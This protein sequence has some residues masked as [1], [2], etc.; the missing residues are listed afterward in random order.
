VLTLGGVVYKKLYR[1]VQERA[2]VDQ[3]P[4][5]RTADGMTAGH[6]GVAFYH[7]AIAEDKG[8]PGQTVKEFRIGLHLALFAD[9]Q[10]RHLNHGIVNA[11]PRIDLKWLD[12]Q[13]IEYKLADGRGEVLSVAQFQ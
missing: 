7:V 4:I 8:P 9:D 13:R 12:D 11:L 1:V 3:L 6:T 5:S 10:V 2:I